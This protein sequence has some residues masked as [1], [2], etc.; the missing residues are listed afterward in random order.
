MGDFNVA[1]EPRDV[2]NAVNYQQLY[3]GEELEAMKELV[4]VCGGGE[5]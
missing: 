1:A 2:H 4:K 3:D 5:R